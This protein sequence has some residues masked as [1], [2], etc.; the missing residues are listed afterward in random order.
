[1]ATV[2][3]LRST[4]ATNTPSSLVSG[5]IAINEADGVLFYRSAAGV[6]TPFSPSAS[7]PDGF[8]YD[9]GVFAATVPAAPTGLTVTPGGAQ[10][11]LAW[12]APAITGGA[13]ITDYRIQYSF[14]S[15]SFTTFSRAASTS[16]TATITGLA[17]GN[18]VFRV[19]AINSVGTGSDVT[20]SSISISASASV[21]TMTRTNNGGVITTW[22]S[23]VGTTASPFTRAASVALG[24]ADG[25]E[26]YYWTA[27]ATATVTVVFN[28]TDG[29]G[30]GESFYINRTRS[31]STVTQA[32]GT[33]GTAITVAV[34]VISG[35]VIR[36]SSS[37]YAPAQYF[38]N[39]S[40][41]AA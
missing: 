26:N 6:V 31:G 33:D 3:I 20:S 12:T 23:G 19:A 8:V 34:S 5:Q 9:C 7:I 4:T 32:Q 35:D 30:A 37:G 1:M 40:V 10:A 18:Y 15:G 21:L 22:G 24:D 13:A 17:T 38:S 29:D 36:F 27:S 25:L 11:A 14:N 2:R 28:Y 41:S 16:T 39:V